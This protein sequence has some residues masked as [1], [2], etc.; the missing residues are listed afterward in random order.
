MAQTEL[1]L[2]LPSTPQRTTCRGALP[3][4]D[5]NMRWMKTQ[6]LLPAGTAGMAREDGDDLPRGNTISRV[7]LGFIYYA[8][9][10]LKLRH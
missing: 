6:D 5:K 9:L 3:L 4:A 8:R 10:K 1:L 2:F 7:W